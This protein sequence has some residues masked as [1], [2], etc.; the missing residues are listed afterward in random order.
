MFTDELK[1]EIENVEWE[2]IE[3]FYGGS[4]YRAGKYKIKEE[5]LDNGRETRTHIYSYFDEESNGYIEFG[6]T[7]DYG[8][9]I[10]EPYT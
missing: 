3:H 2:E 5:S 8:D 1:E 9:I 7:Q 6:Y 4:I 10:Y